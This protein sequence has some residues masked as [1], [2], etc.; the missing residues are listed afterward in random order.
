MCMYI[1]IYDNNNNNKRVK[2]N[3]H[4]SNTCFLQTCLRRQRPQGAELLALARQARGELLL[5]SSSSSSY[6]YYYYSWLSWRTAQ[7]ARVSFL[8]FASSVQLNKSGLV[9]S[10]V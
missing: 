5:V 10:N 7:W 6:Y 2:Y 3:K 9:S 4:M 1:H 8:S